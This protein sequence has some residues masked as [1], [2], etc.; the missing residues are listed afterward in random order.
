[1]Q[2][3]S[4]AG[5]PP[6]QAQILGGTPPGNPMFMYEVFCV[7][8]N[9]LSTPKILSCPSDDSVT[10]TN[11]VMQSTGAAGTVGGQYTMGNINVSY[12][13]GRDAT[14]ESPQMFLAGDRNIS[15]SVTI[16]TYNATQN[17]GYGNS[18][19]HNGTTS[20]GLAVSMGT[21]WP[22]TATAPCWTAKIH[23]TQGNVLLSD[24]SVQQFS[25]SRLRD[26][27]RNTGDTTT[28]PGPNTL[29]FP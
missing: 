12:F 5:G 21:N 16:T 10:H 8:S 17:N 27:L 9:E 3:T 29:L 20:A 1:M 13:I 23:Q 15:G 25:S 22:A 7:M 18:P 24:G 28:L 6:Q 19:D 14:E 11:F 2:V 4:D 26:A